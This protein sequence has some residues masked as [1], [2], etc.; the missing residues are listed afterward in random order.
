MRNTNPFKARQP[1][2]PTLNFH[3]LL[4]AVIEQV[5]LD[6]TLAADQITSRLSIPLDLATLVIQQAH[7][8][9]DR[10]PLKNEKHPL[11]EAFQEEDEN[12][13]KEEQE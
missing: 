3:P 1:G 4:S 9:L 6:Q 12:Q 5:L 2:P 13:N 8:V 11:P 10:Y 7:K